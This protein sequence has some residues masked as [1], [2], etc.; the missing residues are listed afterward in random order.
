MSN[1]RLPSAL[2]CITHVDHIAEHAELK[3]TIYSSHAI[4]VPLEDRGKKN[5]DQEEFRQDADI[6]RVT[7]QLKACI[8]LSSKWR[9]MWK[10]ALLEAHLDEVVQGVLR[11][12]R[13]FFLRHR[14]HSLFASSSSS[15][16]R[17]REG[18]R[19]CETIHT[20]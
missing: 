18:E 7:T 16:E 5:T 17:E 1:F 13:A 3:C 20:C 10:H 2:T 8:A 15:A 11:G 12:G 6:T 4:N 14:D 9:K 19:E